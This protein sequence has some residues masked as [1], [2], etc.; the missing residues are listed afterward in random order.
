MGYITGRDAGQHTKS[1]GGGGREGRE[2]GGGHL[3]ITPLPKQTARSS[4]TAF[5]RGAMGQEHIQWCVWCEGIRS[6][7]ATSGRERDVVTAK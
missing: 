4:P 1:G 2:G 7:V 5:G 6:G 3:C